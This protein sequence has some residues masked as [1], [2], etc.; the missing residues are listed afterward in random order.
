MIMDNQTH[1]RDQRDLAQVFDAV[2]ARLAFFDLNGNL[3]YANRAALD[4]WSAAS[5]G[6]QVNRATQQFATALCCQIRENLA[7]NP[8]NVREI[9]S[10]NVQI[11]GG[12]FRF[13]GSY[14]GGNLFGHGSTVLIA[15][16][17]VPAEFLSDDAL[18]QRFGLTAREVQVARLLAE[19]KTNVQI[20]AEMY[21]SPH[22]ARTHT[23]RV[24]QKLGAHSRAEVGSIFRQS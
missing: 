2:P 11:G 21:I 4:V 23:E 16:E 14:I 7:A 10:H 13:V 3:L 22:T 6:V 12:K 5:H 8:K 17:P 20:A 18:G 9:A 24:L 1:G 15:I 19:G